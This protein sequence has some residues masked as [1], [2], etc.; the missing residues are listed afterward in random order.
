MKRYTGFVIAMSAILLF[1]G[2]IHAQFEFQERDTLTIVSHPALRHS[3]PQMPASP[4]AYKSSNGFEGLLAARFQF[5]LDSMLFTH[6]L[7]GASA[8][9]I[10][11]EK[12]TWLGAG[13][14]SNPVTNDSM[15]T[16]MLLEIDSNTKSFV[17]AIILQMVEEGSLSLED[18]ISQWLP[19]FANVDSTM[20]IRQL[21]QHTG[22]VSDYFNDN[23]A[24]LLA[25][26]NDPTLFWT[27]EYTLTYVLQPNFPPGAA[28][29]YSNT[30]YTLAGMIIREISGVDSFT[31]PLHQRLLEPFNLQHTFVDIEESLVGELA[32]NWNDLNGDGILDDLT[33]IPRTA[34][35]SSLWTAGAIVSTAEDLAKWVY[36]LHGDQ[37]LS[38]TAMQE[39]RN[40]VPIPG[41]PVR[42][43]LGIYSFPVLGKTLWGHDG[44]GIGFNSQALFYRERGVSIAVIMNQRGGTASSAEILR[45]LFRVV[46][47]YYEQPHDHPY[48]IN[49]A[50]NPR[51]LHPQSDTAAVTAKILNPENHQFTVAAIYANSDSTVIDT[52]PMFDDGLHGDSLAGDN[53]YGAIL[54]PLSDESNYDVRI[55]TTDTDSAF[56]HFKSTIFTTQGPI[57]FQDFSLQ[58]T[59]GTLYALKISLKNE[60]STSVVPNVSLRIETAD[61]A[62]TQILNANPV[63]GSFLPGEVKQTPAYSLLNIPDFSAPVTIN[64]HIAIDNNIFWDD[65][66]IIEPPTGL[67]SDGDAAPVTFSLE[68]NYPNPFNPATTIRFE[69]PS[70]GFTT[71]TIYNSLGESVKTLISQKIAAGS[72]SLDWDASGMSSGIYFYR[73]SAGEFNQIRKMVLIR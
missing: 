9:I 29:R 14:F 39:M 25:I 13:G 20:T 69:L 53:L 31:V 21:L 35:M 28:W 19:T 48:A 45:E 40:T 56:T 72:Y 60:S 44:G 67:H 11:P 6:N 46:F 23:P 37:V 22:G 34:W 36:L 59:A 54:G 24:T 70:A 8:A 32:H 51:Y 63:F 64:I 41:T 52:L 65:S 3:P 15:R 57:T 43:G 66:F 2:T 10:L 16:D 73:L 58:S 38:T 27:P 62:V 71:L 5:V 30:G 55:K 4:Q 17:A 42:Y 61:T 50:V 49:A 33:V 68:Q 1:S 26:L 18:P 47:K 12:G 7:M